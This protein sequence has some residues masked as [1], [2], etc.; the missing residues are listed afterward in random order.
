MQRMV[1]CQKY[2]QELPG[3]SHPPYPGPKGEYIFRHI[4][5]KAWTAWQEHQTRL[6]NER[7]L[8]LMDKATR[9]LLKQE[10]ERFFAGE[11]LSHISGYQEA[12]DV[13]SE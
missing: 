7:Q 12:I 9:D 10:M 4:S 11:K 5:Q 3:L 13:K 1:F 2:K 8:N 6:I